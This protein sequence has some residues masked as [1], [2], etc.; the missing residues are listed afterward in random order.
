MAEKKIDLTIVI[1]TVPNRTVQALD[2]FKRFSD[3][4]P[5]NFEILLIGDNKQR[6]IGKKREMGLKLAQGKYITWYDDDDDFT[7]YTMPEFARAVKEDKDVIVGYSL[8]IVNGQPG[9]I[10][11]DRSNISEEFKPE[12]LTKR[13]PFPQ[14]C[15]WKRS[16]VKDIPFPDKMYAEDSGWAEKALKNIRTQSKIRKVIHIYNHDSNKSE[17]VHS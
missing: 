16:L 8:V 17:A 4:A 14:G 11:F 3:A 6:S 1:C 13:Y 2:L 7:V 5:D 12:G 10:E 9:Y 15:A